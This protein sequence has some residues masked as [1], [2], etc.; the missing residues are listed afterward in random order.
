MHEEMLEIVNSEGTAIGL[1]LRSEIHGNP[2]LLHKVV[3]ILVFNDSDELLLQKRSMSKDVAPGKW[4][5]SVGGHF[6]PGEDSLAAALRE[7][8]EE[9]GVVSDNYEYLYSYLYTN[10]YESEM[11][12]TLRCLHNGPFSFNKEEIDEIAF[13]DMDKIKKAIGGG[14]LSDNFEI[15]IK[16][17]FSVLL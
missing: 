3:H 10:N 5:T 15:E 11:V 12:F 14:V 17:Y 13:W 7:M 9:L 2:S 6:A 1:K 4:D 8:E 16:H